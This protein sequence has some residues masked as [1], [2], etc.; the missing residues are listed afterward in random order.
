MENQRHEIFNIIN[1]IT[2]LTKEVYEELLSKYDKKLVDS[3]I[4]VQIDE[5]GIYKFEYYIDLKL[6]ELEESYSSSYQSYIRDVNSNGKFNNS[7]NDKYLA[8][9]E[10]VVD[11]LNSL[12]NLLGY[13]QE[14]C[15]LSIIE[16]VDF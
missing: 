15:G 14:V 1:G 4:E 5:N 10:L 16:K 11:R 12:F 7:D 3:I 2:E 6:E 8:D 9:L 13:K